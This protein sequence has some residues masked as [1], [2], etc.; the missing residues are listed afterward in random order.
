MKILH[1]LGQRPEKTGSGIYLH[2]MMRKAREQGLSVHM[3]AGVPEGPLPDLEDLT[4]GE[5][6]YVFFE[7]GELP[8]AVPGMSDVMPYKSS[9]FRDLKSGRL[10]AYQTAFGRELKKA[11]DRFQPDVIHSNHLFVL[12][13]LVRKLFP[14][15]PLVTTCHGTDLRQYHNCEHLRA[16][17]KAYSQRI[18]RVIALTHDQ[19]DDI[20]RTLGIPPGQIVVTGGGYDETCF[21]RAP[22]SPEGPV[23]ILYAGKFIIAVG[24]GIG[25]HFIFAELAG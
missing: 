15:V 9:L 7:S 4:A 3:L 22:K 10:A 2:A 14:Q 17:V 6:S 5:C 12:T 20:V 19:K 13:A 23:Q 18:D 24:V 21:N 16:F 11:V 1:V 25:Y 8:F